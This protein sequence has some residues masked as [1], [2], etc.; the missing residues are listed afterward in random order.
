MK[1]RWAAAAAVLLLVLCAAAALLFSDRMQNALI[2][3]RINRGLGVVD[4]ALSGPDALRLALIGSGGPLANDRRSSPCLAVAAGRTVFLVDAGPGAWKNINRFRLPAA[5]I[6]FV[7]LTHFHSDHIGD[8]GE[9]S[10]QTWVAGRAAPL[11]VYG[12]PGV[13]KVAAGFQ[14]AYALDAGYRVAHH[15]T[16]TMP[17]EAGRINSSVFNLDEDQ[18]TMVYDRDGL[19]IAAFRVDHQ[20]ASPACGYRIEYRGRVLVVSGDTSKSANLIRH[21]RGADLLV[22]CA[23]SERLMGRIAWAAASKGLTRQAQMA[24]DVLTYQASPVQAA[25]SA[26]EAGV[27]MLALVHVTPPLPNRAAERIFLTGV[28][29]AWAGETV[30][31]EDGQLFTLPVDSKNVEIKKLD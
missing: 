6:G 5:D 1:R 19:T 31:G 22:H 23:L 21:A 11:L 14:A 29:D 20:P 8:L 30:L 25:E 17:E 16:A 13:E 26:R 28:K 10:M 9:L 15:G 7:L 27:K 2:D 24:A 3:H 4:P 12:P 18:R